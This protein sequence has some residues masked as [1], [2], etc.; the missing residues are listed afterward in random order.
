MQA[1]DIY[2][3]LHAVSKATLNRDFSNGGSGRAGAY[4]QGFPPSK[5]GRFCTFQ[6]HSRSAEE[7]P[8]SCNSGRVKKNVLYSDAP[9]IRE[10]PVLRGSCQP[11]SST[12]HIFPS[13]TCT[14]IYS[15]KTKN[16]SGIIGIHFQIIPHLL[17][18]MFNSN[19]KFFNNWRVG[20]DLKVRTIW[21]S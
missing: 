10:K 20:H 2:H 4:Q 19:S 11:W 6:S 1:D 5:W 9:K 17:L 21:L 3:H 18:W 15:I 14:I 8:T 16:N 12:V 13:F 7:I